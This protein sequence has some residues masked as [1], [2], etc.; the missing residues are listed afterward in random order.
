MLPCCDCCHLIHFQGTS[1]GSLST[2]YRTWKTVMVNQHWGYKLS[3]AISELDMEFAIMCGRDAVTKALIFVERRDE[4]KEREEEKGRQWRKQQSS[5]NFS[6]CGTL[7]YTHVCEIIF[8]NRQCY[9]L[10]QEISTQVC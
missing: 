7:Q 5:A 3:T 10:C 9:I 1:E 2:S 8:N 4:D 6:G